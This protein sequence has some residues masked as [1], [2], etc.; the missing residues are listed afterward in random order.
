M[1]SALELTGKALGGLVYTSE[2]NHSAAI[3]QLVDFR[4]YVYEEGNLKEYDYGRTSYSNRPTN[5][6]G[7]VMLSLL[8]SRE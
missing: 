8:I 2:R 3:N 5:M 1:R 6:Q 7:L 4:R